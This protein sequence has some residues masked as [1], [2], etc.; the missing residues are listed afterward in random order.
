MI[1]GLNT[2]AIYN[3]ISAGN[4]S[5]MGA[6]S[7][8]NSHAAHLWVIDGCSIHVKPRSLTATLTRAD[9]VRIYNVYFHCN[10]GWE[11][12]PDDGYYLIN[13]DMTMTFQTNMYLYDTNFRYIANVKK[14]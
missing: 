3:S 6:N 13:S 2:E 10:M 12:G 8:I 11:G 1:S 14:K 4:I 9:L 5:L 7:S